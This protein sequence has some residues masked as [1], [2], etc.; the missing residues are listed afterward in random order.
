MVD[1]FLFPFSEPGTDAEYEAA[2]EQMLAEMKRLNQQIQD[3]QAEID[4]LK[5]ETATMKEE[6]KRLKAEG[7]QIHSDIRTTLDRLKAAVASC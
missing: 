6:T 5:V 3:D 2:I 1:Q 4:R 7:F